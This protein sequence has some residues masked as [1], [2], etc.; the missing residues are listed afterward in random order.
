MQK[1]TR[2]SLAS[3]FLLGLLSA[4]DPVNVPSPSPTSSSSL[5]PSASPTVDSS[6]QP[7]ASPSASAPGTSA[8]PTAQPSTP[9]S[10]A[11]GKLTVIGANSFDDFNLEFR[12]GMKWTY[13]MKLAGVDIAIPNLPPGV[14]IP[15]L[16]GSSAG[17]NLGDFTMEVI[18]VNGNLITMRTDVNTAIAGSPDPAP[19]EST[20]EKKNISAVY[21]ES[22][23]SNGEGTLTWTSA[24]S[25]S[26]TVP[27]GGY[28]AGVVNGRMN[29][30]ANGIQVNQD[31]K[32]WIANGVGMVKQ[33]V[34]SEAAGTKSTTIVELQ[35][36]SG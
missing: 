4:C 25:E 35:S 32:V 36:F 18:K 34:V 28:T 23:V 31:T 21:T 7:S 11:N 17:T 27:A 24:G 10:T 3:I 8:S 9:P 19:T 15:G 13:K 1:I 26:V 2:V 5:N 16:G 20:F 6:A 14:T 30:T 22:F 12:E 29:V 33:E